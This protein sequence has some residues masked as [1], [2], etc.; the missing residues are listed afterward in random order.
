[1]R[2][3]EIITEST[4]PM[5][6]DTALS[7]WARTEGKRASAFISGNIQARA[8]EFAGNGLEPADAVNAAHNSLEREEQALIAKRNQEKNKPAPTAPSK[9]VP[10]KP[11]KPQYAG[12]TDK[13][14]MPSLSGASNSLS[15]L[16]KGVSSRLNKGAAMADQF[17]LAKRK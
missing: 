12:T 7:V 14:K 2:L 1:M 17:T 9:S 8:R 5:T 11:S 3:H 16:V 4:T 6:I 15:N 13:I 10:Q